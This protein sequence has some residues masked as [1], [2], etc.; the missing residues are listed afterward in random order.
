MSAPAGL[1]ARIVR[2]TRESHGRFAGSGQLRNW[3]RPN[4]D[5]LWR[6]VG[7]SN[8]MRLSAKKVAHRCSRP[9]PRCRKSGKRE[10]FLWFSL[11]QN[12]TS[13]S[14]S[15]HSNC[16]TALG[17][18]PQVAAQAIGVAV[19]QQCFHFQVGSLPDRRSVGEQSPALSCQADPSTTPV[20]R[21]GGDLDQAAALQ[22][23]QCGGQGGAI[24][25]EQRCHRPHARRLRTIQRHQQ[26]VLTVRQPDRPQCL[27]E[28]PRQRPRR[29][30]H[31]QTEATI[32]NPQR[33]F[34][35]NNGLS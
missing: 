8:C 13:R 24:Y 31:V 5:F 9:V 7:P 10:A 15:G 32:A 1:V 19:R 20:R 11:K 18:R 29:P 14:L 33:N 35:R 12:H 22:R 26:R 21:I 4:P 17:E 28:I 27:V 16:E 2:I 25:S 6:F 23:L 34:K 30:L 3:C